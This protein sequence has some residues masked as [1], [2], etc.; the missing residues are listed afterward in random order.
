[1][2]PIMGLFWQISCQ[3]TIYTIRKKKAA[4]TRIRGCEGQYMGLNL[5]FVLRIRQIF[6]VF[7]T[8][9]KKEGYYR[10]LW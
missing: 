5:G 6:S 3:T 2:D 10:V 4:R 7:S 1:M 8:G 9:T